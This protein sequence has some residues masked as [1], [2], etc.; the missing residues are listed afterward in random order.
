MISL[1]SG[2]LFVARIGGQVSLL[3]GGVGQLVAA[4]VF[5]GAI[6]G[7]DPFEFDGVLVA[8]FQQ[9]GPQVG[10]FGGFFFVAHP[11]LATPFFGPAF[12]EAVD[13]VLGVAEDDDVGFYLQGLQANDA[14]QDFHAVVGGLAKA[15]REFFNA[16]FVFQD[17]AIAAGAG[18]G[19]GAAIGE[20][21]DFPG[22]QV[23]GDGLRQGGQG[24]AFFFQVFHQAR[25]QFEQGFQGEF[26]QPVEGFFT[27]VKAFVD[28][29]GEV[30]DLL[31]GL[32]GAE[33]LGV[34]TG[35]AAVDDEVELLF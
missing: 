15:A 7:F 11:A 5:A 4:L 12:G 23:C 14:G 25:R 16:V 13:D 34:D 27:G 24:V 29:F 10:V 9:L 20:N 21:D 35:L 3:R 28:G 33:P 18:F 19:M 32:A 30:C 2:L 6:V 1:S 31:G 22:F 26:S 8:K 17:D